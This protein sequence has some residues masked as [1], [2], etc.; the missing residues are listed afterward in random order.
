[1]ID[2]ITVA[3][4]GL[5]H[6]HIFPRVQLLAE[7]PD[8]TLA[9]C[10]DPD[11]ALR[12]GVAERCNLPAFD[13]LDALLD[14]PGV[15]FVVAEGWD[16]ANPA[17]V[18]EALKRKQAVLVEKPGA[19]SLAQ[20]QTLVRA[21]REAQVPFQVGYMLRFS[22]VVETIADLLAQDVLGDITLARFHAA[23]P[24]GC[25][26]EQW[27]SVP[28]DMGGVV[29]TDGCHMVDIIVNLLG[30]PR[31]VK[32]ALLKLPE[33]RT[34]LSHGFKAHT[35]SELDETVE[36]PLGGLMYEDG[37]VAVL[38][39][40][41]KLAVYDVTGWEAHPWV[42]AWRIELYGTNGTLHAGLNPAWHRLYVRN[43]VE[44]Y[45]PGWHSWSDLQ[46]L[47]VANSLVVDDNYRR[48]MQ[49]ML[50]RVRRWDTDNDQWL[51]E[52]HGTIAILDA[53]FRSA[54]QNDAVPVTLDETHATD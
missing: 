44:G 9:G 28:G 6:P 40:D 49:H 20:T 52:A 8:V 50:D 43:A 41:D 36:M 7:Q 46:E 10:Y 13:S 24:V 30:I 53:M 4:A 25:A 51:H 23:S 26:A 48:E 35:L 37:G 31:S 18:L 17:I 39:Y 47:G 38:E 3:F 45:A 1:M 33:G 22:S 14:Q 29:F 54:A 42:E 16:T 21:V 19:P 34:V 2:S 27:Q 12:A 32:G 11:P 5:V 15:N